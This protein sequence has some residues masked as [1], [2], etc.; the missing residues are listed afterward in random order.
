MGDR[1]WKRGHRSVAVEGKAS[2]GIGTGEGLEVTGEGLE[3]SGSRG[4]QVS[5]MGQRLRVMEQGQT[6]QD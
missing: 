1:A 3:V 4:C 5:F 2:P 6:V